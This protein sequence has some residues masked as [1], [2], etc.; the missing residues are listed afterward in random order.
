MA[1]LSWNQQY[2]TGVPS[3]DEQHG[4]LIALINQLHDAMKTGH[5]RDA[6]GSVLD[7]L[8]DY[9]R[10]HFAAEERLM[11]THAYPGILRHRRIHEDLTAKVVAIQAQ[12]RSGQP[13]LTIEVM[14]FL[15]QWLVTHIQGAD[16][17][18]GVV[19][20]GKGVS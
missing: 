3:M 19:L 6:L 20:S 12:V 9:T 18:Y 13:V 5:G 17:E 1:F 4:K 11:T 10:T 15:R 2:S 7:A 14:D 16:K 8:V